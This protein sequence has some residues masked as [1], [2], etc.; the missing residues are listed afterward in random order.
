VYRR[1]LA[2]AARLS[3]PKR[4]LAYGKLDLDLAAMRRR[5][6]PLAT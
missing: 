4:Y 6:P 5:W 2:R 1:K 3:G